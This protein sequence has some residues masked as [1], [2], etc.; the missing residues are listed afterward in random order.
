MHSSQRSDAMATT[1]PTSRCNVPGCTRVTW[2]GESGT[3]CCRTCN[4]SGGASHGPVCDETNVTS[5]EEEKEECISDAGLS[6]STASTCIGDQWQKIRQVLSALRKCGMKSCHSKCCLYFVL[7]FLLFI[8]TGFLWSLIRHPAAVVLT[9]PH[10]LLWVWWCKKG[11]DRPSKEIK[12]EKEL[13]EEV[14]C[15]QVFC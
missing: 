5:E 4:A 1:A 12:E 13:A 6:A 15:R 10:S 9:V 7:W 8:F 14:G 3:Q 2:N 11:E